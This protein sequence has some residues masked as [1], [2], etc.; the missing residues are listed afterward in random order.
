MEES[1]H[2]VIFVLDD[3]R[4]ALRLSAVE[5]VVR[6]V[7]ITPLPEA[8]TVVPGVIDVAGRIIAV[9][10]VRRRFSLPAR[11]AGLD[12]RLLIART[13]RR[14]VAL[15]ADAVTGVRDCPERDIVAAGGVVPG[16]GQ[17]AGIATLEGDPAQGGLVL[18]HDLDRF[19]DLDEERSLDQALAAAEDQ[20]AC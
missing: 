14:T 15:I 9:F 12:D 8:P 5:R 11:E 7:R 16:A 3:Q 4:Y 1:S 2:L 20:R 17:I 10:D 13:A 18:I 19:L 6:M